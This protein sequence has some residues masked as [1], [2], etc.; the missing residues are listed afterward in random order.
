M[1]RDYEIPLD[2]S[3]HLEDGIQATKLALGSELHERLMIPCPYIRRILQQLCSRGSKGRGSGQISAYSKLELEQWIGEHR[4]FLMSFLMLETVPQQERKKPPRFV[5]QGGKRSRVDSDNIHEEEEKDQE[6]MEAVEIDEGDDAQDTF[7]LSAKS[8]ELLQLWAH[9]AS[10]APELV[11][12][13]HEL[14]ITVSDI[15]YEGMLDV[16]G[17]SEISKWSPAL[18]HF[19]TV[20][21]RWEGDVNMRDF[22]EDN[23]KPLGMDARRLLKKSVELAR[24][25]MCGQSASNQSEPYTSSRDASEFEDF[26]RTG[27]WAPHNPVIRR[28]PWYRREYENC[29]SRRRVDKTKDEEKA[30][31]VQTLSEEVKHTGVTCNKYKERHSALTPGLFT[32]FCLHCKLCVAFE[33]MENTESPGT[34]FRMFAHRAWTCQDFKILRRWKQDGIWEDTAMFCGKDGVVDFWMPDRLHPDLR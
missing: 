13:P 21:R 7:W 15:V 25:S 14:L 31:A 22:T 17:G 34:A 1:E 20:V 11:F 16:Q 19:L 9:Y 8:V 28:L 12:I 18:H 3:Q 29:L 26:I 33:L 2:Y 5:K 27:T 32:V 10:P 24:A 6:V 23:V 30:A 4:K